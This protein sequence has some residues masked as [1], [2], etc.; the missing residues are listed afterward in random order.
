MYRLAGRYRSSLLLNFAIHKILMQ[1]GREAEVA[2]VGASLAGYFGVFHRCLL[3]LCVCVC[4]YNA[5]STLAWSTG[6]CPVCACACVH[7]MLGLL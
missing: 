5:R 1:P 2:A 6:T 7:V 4:A 3:C